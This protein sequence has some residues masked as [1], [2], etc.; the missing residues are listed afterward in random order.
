M[1]AQADQLGVDPGRL[2]AERLGRVSGV[3]EPVLRIG[4]ILFGPV[5]GGGDLVAAGGEVLRGLD[6]IQAGL[7]EQLPKPLGPVHPVA[8]RGLALF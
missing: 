6:R 4:E 7:R 2:V 8:T 1:L 3:G 5:A